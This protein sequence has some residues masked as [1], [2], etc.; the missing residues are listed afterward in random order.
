MKH[1]I[2]FTIGALVLSLPALAYGQLYR[3][4][5]GTQL[6]HPYVAVQAGVSFLSDSDV[7]YSSGAT[8]EASFDTGYD[9]SLKVGT[10][11]NQLRI[12]GQVQ[13]AE[14]DLDEIRAGS[15]VANASGDISVTAFTANA[16]WV[17]APQQ[18]FHPYIGAGAGFAEVALNDVS[19]GGTKVAD[20]SDTVFAY[21]L[22]VGVEVD[23]APRAALYAGYHYLATADPEF[24][25]VGG[26]NFE[27]EYASHN[28]AVGL[29]YSF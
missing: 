23:V 21:Q 6:Y 10:Q 20:D 14:N 8:R 28:I 16:I 7:S 1:A 5:S 13:Y 9:V 25:D 3:P 19:A 18:K 4:A 26:S 15:V 17:L 24:Q 12:E 2:R 11:I 22:M 29:R 27:A